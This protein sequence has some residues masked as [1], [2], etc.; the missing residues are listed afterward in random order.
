MV[1]SFT[2][3]FYCVGDDLAFPVTLRERAL[4]T[5]S[6]ALGGDWPLKKKAGLANIE[7]LGLG[8]EVA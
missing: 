7:K 5:L 3:L 1:L 6:G 4:F 2:S 8:A